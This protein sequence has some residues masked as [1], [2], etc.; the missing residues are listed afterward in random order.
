MPTTTVALDRTFA[1]PEID[2]RVLDLLGLEYTSDRF[3]PIAEEPVPAAAGGQ[4]GES[5]FQIRADD[6]LELVRICVMLGRTFASDNDA[7][8]F[9]TQ[10]TAVS[11][12]DGGPTVVA[13]R[14][15]LAPQ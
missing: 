1:R 2:S 15:H 6:V 13:R 8:D 7:A 9:A 10:L 11:S 12:R 14:Y 3:C 4:P 5:A